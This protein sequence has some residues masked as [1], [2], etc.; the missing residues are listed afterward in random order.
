MRVEKNLFF[1]G[2]P[3]VGFALPC[4]GLWWPLVLALARVGLGS[5]LCRLLVARGGAC[6]FS[7]FLGAKFA[8]R[9]G[10]GVP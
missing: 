4:L 9:R 6:G 3:L 5:L 7:G 10:G 8:P 2:V 1:L